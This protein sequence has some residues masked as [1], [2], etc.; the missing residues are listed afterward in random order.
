MFVQIF[1]FVKFCIKI[2]EKYQFYAYLIQI[3]VL[4]VFVVLELM[5][6]FSNRY[7]KR[8]DN[9]EQNSI[10][11]FKEIIRE[12]EICRLE[13][14]NINQ[15]KCLDVLLEK[16]RYSDPVSSPKVEQEN[17][18]IHE[19]IAELQNIT[20]QELFQEKCDEITKQLEIRKIKNV[21]EHS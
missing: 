7:I 19:L 18:K 10:C 17:K 13:V 21:K 11:D 16:M 15:Q 1:I 3:V 8:V 6:F 5:L 2:P 4:V 20:E 14:A 12:L 9:S